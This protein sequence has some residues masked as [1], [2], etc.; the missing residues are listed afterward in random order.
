MSV[1]YGWGN[2]VEPS[3]EQ[4]GRSFGRESAA[5]KYSGLQSEREQK[6][7]YKSQA[8]TYDALRFARRIHR[9]ERPRPLPA[10]TPNGPG[11][12]AGLRAEA[13]GDAEI[14]V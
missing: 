9:R 6:R 10:P 14:R 3:R 1:L 13:A 8:T 5:A 11:G 7:R 2:D 4:P 12:A